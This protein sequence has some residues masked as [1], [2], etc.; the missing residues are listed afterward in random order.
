[1]RRRRPS[2]GLIAAWLAAWCL[3][4]SCGETAPPVTVAVEVELTRDGRNYDDPCFWQDPTA[5]GRYLAFMTSKDDGLVDVWEMPSRTHVGQVTGFRGRTNNCAVDQVRNL[6]VTT[7]PEAGAV[8]VHALPGFG[9]VAVARHPQLEEP[10]GVAVGHEGNESF[11]FVTD[12]RRLEVH[13][14]SLPDGR[15]VRSFPYR[16]TKAEGISAD[17]DLQGLYV[18]DDRS[19]SHGTKAFTFAG[20]ELREF[21]IDETGSDSEGNALYRCGPR[22]GYVIVSDQRE[23][24]SRRAYSEFEVFDR[25]TFAHRGTFRLEAGDGD[26]TGSTDGIDVFQ[27]PAT[28]A[29]GGIFAACDGCGGHGQ[30]VDEL[31]VVPWDRIARALGLRVCPNGALPDAPA[32][33]TGAVS[34]GP[35]PTER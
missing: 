34:P 3:A 14:L 16:L 4:A 12:E 24:G 35:G 20:V 7:D 25:E 5:E 33:P 22:A 21:G 23:S 27:G 28:A 9:R 30:A 15:W 11:A 32:A 26:W 1:M 6:L 13:V 10:S 19:D 29:T 8:H 18:S 2:R 31:D 17:D